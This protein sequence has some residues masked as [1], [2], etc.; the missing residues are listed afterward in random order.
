MI[1]R[2]I[3]RA[4]QGPPF[5]CT[6][7]PYEPDQA[8]VVGV[9]TGGTFTD[10]VVI[11]PC[12]AVRVDK[13][14]SDPADP[15]GPVLEGLTG[16]PQE[17]YRVVHGTTVA[18]NALLEH[19]EAPTALITT[20]GF[21]DVLEIGRQNRPVLY[22]AHPVK[23]APLVP[24]H[25]RFGVNERILSDGTVRTRLDSV[26]TERILARIKDLGVESLAVCLLHS[27]ANP[28]HEETIGEIAREMG[29]VV[30]LS[31]K[32]LPEFREYERTATVVV[33]ACLRPIMEGYI[34]RLEKELSGGRLSVMQ[35]AGGIIPARMASRLPV[36]TVLSGPAG[37]VAASA[38]QASL[39][40]LERLI[41]FDMGGTSTDVSLYDRGPSLTGDKSIAGHPIRVPAIDIHTV[42]AGGGSIAYRDAGG[43]L[44]VGPVSAG[45]NPGP[46]C[47]GK[48]GDITVTDANLYLGRLEPSFFLGGRMRVYPGRVKG[49]MERLARSLGLDPV[50]AAE[51]IITVV[52]AV[53]E[54]AVRV[55]SI[56]QGHD[57]RDFT[58]VSFG[59]AGGLHAVELAK[60]LSIP[61][62]MVPKNAGVFSAF[63]MAVANVIRD[64]SR[65]ILAPSADVPESRLRDLF[66]EMR[67]SGIQ[68]LEAEGP[69][70]RGIQAVQ[71]LD[72]RYVGQSYELTVPFTRD[73]VAA[74]HEAHE[75]LYGYGRPESAVEIV[76]LRLRLVAES[77]TP[78]PQPVK[79][80]REGKPPRAVS[81]G[82]VIYRGEGAEVGIYDREDLSPGNML[83]GP[84]LIGE[85]SS[86]T[87]LPPGSRGTVDALGNIII[88]TGSETA[89]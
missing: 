72:M 37:G 57:P 83:E 42:G 44:K 71:S 38:Y 12:G 26:E 50:V 1:F 74:F 48:G 20:A 63:G 45:A 11:D 82:T 21:E 24:R 8:R 30:S 81:T 87:F 31:C 32:V 53:M 56:E 34:G 79:R 58:L 84:A 64:V 76:T 46:V 51:G 2:E 9:D 66:A 67:L 65:T 7:M 73:H 33:N 68:E 14:P 69:E 88:A 40:G 86:T 85:S 70:G 89:L 52:N 49:P 29:F 43:G 41:T 23:P 13:R 27:Y 39:V 77:G 25:L 55:I 15:A 36:H 18:V 75:R 60:A 19:K 54:R 28:I 5:L 4:A 6:I 3:Q 47:Y 10:F 80:V 62:V 16:L 17:A 22:D 35:S 61:R 78:A 59:G